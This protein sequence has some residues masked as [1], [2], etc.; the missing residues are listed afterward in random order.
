[1]PQSLHRLI[2]KILQYDLQHSIFKSLTGNSQ[3]SSSSSTSSAIVATPQTLEQLLERQW[4]QGSQFLMEQAQHLDIAQLLSCLNQ[5]KQDNKALEEHVQSLIQRRDQ[6]TA[7]NARLNIPL[8]SSSALGSLGG[9]FLGGGVVA[10][11]NAHHNGYSIN[12]ST[13]SP[14]VHPHSHG[15]PGQGG[16]PKNHP[17]ANPAPSPQQHDHVAASHGRERN[18]YNLSDLPSANKF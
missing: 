10:N 4:E 14:N 2:I 17:V 6:L 7:I 15:P 3:A 5:L 13:P 8:G 1:M 16:P 18:N 9:A 11:T 12:Q